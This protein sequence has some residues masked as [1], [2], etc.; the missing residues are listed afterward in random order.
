MQEPSAPFSFSN[1]YAEELPDFY[2]ESAPM[3]VQEPSLLQ[4]NAP[5]ADELGLGVGELPS[6]DLAQIFSG[7]KLLAGSRPLAQAYA[8]HQ[9]GGF[10]PQLGDGRGLLLGEVAAPDGRRRDIALKGS[11]RTAYSRGGDG[12][13]AIGPVLREYLLGEAMHTLGIPTTRS[14]AAVATGE[15]VYRE[16]T[17]PGAIL[18]R[19]ASS[20]IRI[21]T[22]EF[23]ASQQ[24]WDQV[25]Q[26]A[27]YAIERHYPHLSSDDDRYL[28]FLQ[29]VSERQAA[30]VANWMLIGFIHG[31]MNT[32]NMAISGETIDY[33]PCAF[34]EAFS[35]DAVFSSIDQR[36]RYAYKN[37]PQMAQWNLTRFAEALLPLIDKDNP[38]RAVPK[39]EAI[40]NDFTFHYEKH[41]LAGAQAKLGLENSDLD[42][43]SDKVLVNDWLN[44]LEIYA[45]DY[46][47][48]WRRLADAA[49]G[50]SESL[51]A[52]FPSSEVLSPWLNRW[53]ERIAKQSAADSASRMRSVNP[54]Y[55]PRNHFVE[56]ALDAATNDSNLEP[57]EKL[58]AVLSHPFDERPELA[59]YAQPAPENFT[60]RY[61]TFCGT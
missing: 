39:V 24:R 47:L 2:V 46:T 27:D 8:G 9:F 25:K 36:G 58:L 33:G 59:S 60:G 41:W 6:Q 21:G 57:F 44:L 29:A 3:A 17:L 1:S 31:V 13:A 54:I 12:K 61:K 32:D 22:F 7:Q 23:F 48:A 56:D 38:E 11:G 4:F 18:T 28:L 34:M 43:D 16:N 42:V 5:L 40:L 30:L 20:H 55:I 49:E 35:P 50:N 26:L 51:E 45:V 15:S 14:L 19:V 53:H 10:S 52:L 37:Q